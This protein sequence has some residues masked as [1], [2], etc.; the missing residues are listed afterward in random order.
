MRARCSDRAPASR[1]PDVKVRQELR[2]PAPDLRRPPPSRPATNGRTKPRS[3][4]SDRSRSSARARPVSFDRSA[5]QPG[6][7][8]LRSGVGRRKALHQPQGE[9]H[10]A[11]ADR[12]RNRFLGDRLIGRARIDQLGEQ[13]RRTGMIAVDRGRARLEIGPRPRSTGRDATPALA[14]ARPPSAADASKQLTCSDNS[15][16]H[17]PRA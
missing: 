11:G 9:L 1:L 8:A 2:A 5:P 3:P 4:A 16:L 7:T 15:V 12:L 14:E 13:L 6:A 17:R 10:V